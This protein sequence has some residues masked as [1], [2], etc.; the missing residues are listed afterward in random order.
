M[1]R[2][3]EIANDKQA[4]QAIKK[5]KLKLIIQLAAVI[6]IYNLFF[7]VSYIT[8]VLKFAI[9]Y[10]RTPSIEALAGIL[11]F[12]TFA[13]NP[14]LTIT[15]QPELNLELITLLFFLGLKIKKA[16]RIS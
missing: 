8:Q 1:K 16:L 15:F 13:L 4:L 7:S 10:I 2:D 5:Q 6:V 12:L 14:L 3:A 9:G 11:T